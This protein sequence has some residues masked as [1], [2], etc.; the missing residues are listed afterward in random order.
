M[1]HYPPLV[2]E[3]V[4]EGQQRGYNFTSPT[5]GYS[6]ETLKFIWRNAMPRGQGWGAYIGAESRKYFPLP[7]GR[8]VLSHMH[9]TDLQDEIGRRGIRRT[10]IDV[11]PQTEYSRVLRT[12][13]DA[14]PLSIQR[15]AD[16]NLREWKRIRA[17]ERSGNQIR[18]VKQLIFSHRYTTLADWRVVEAVMLKLALMPPNPVRSL[19]NPLS[20]TTLALEHREETPVVALPQDRA[21]TAAGIPIFRII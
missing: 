9:V 20:F 18:R 5:R 13:L 3:Y 7:D 21:E 4:T 8:F 6:D 2:I 15:D 12:A 14:L 10:L 17:L 1:T 16:H 19:G 11:F